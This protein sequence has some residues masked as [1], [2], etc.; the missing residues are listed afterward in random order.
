MALVRR[1]LVGLVPRLLA[2]SEAAICNSGLQG[3]GAPSLRDEETSSSGS[4]WMPFRGFASEVTATSPLGLSPCDKLSVMPN[5]NITYDESNHKRLPPSAT[6]GVS[7]AI[8]VQAGGRF[9]YATAARL[10]ALKFILSMTA[11]ADVLAMASL[12][13]D[14]SG[15]AE[16]DGVTVKWRGKPVFIR[17]RTESEIA[18]A[19]GVNL[20]ELRDPQTDSERV[21]DPKY[22]VVVGVCTHLGCVPIAGAGEYNGWFC[23]CHGSHYDISGRIR[24]GPAPTN[25]EVPEYRFLGDGKAIIG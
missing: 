11:S 5:H 10:L 1:G 4:K 25:L 24:K 14:I 23:P 12:E 20:A 2:Q 16:G 8:L 15:I 22:L 13:V 17:H 19:N 6:P 9:F 7:P 3:V 18:E 21:I